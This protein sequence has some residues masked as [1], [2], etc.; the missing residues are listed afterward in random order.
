MAENKRDYYEVLGVSKGASEEEIKKAYKKLARKYHP[1]MNPGDKEAEEKFKEINEAN[2]VLSDPKKR[3]LYDQYGFAGVDPN[4]AAQNGGG[5]GGFG[6][7][8]GFGGDGVDLGDIFGDIFGGGFGGFGGSSRS[9]NPNAPRKGQDIRVRI[10]LTFD[11][12]VHGCKKNITITRQQE[13]TECHGSGCAA[14]SSPETCPDCGG[15]GFVIRQQRTP[16]GVMQTQQP[17][18]RCGGKGKLIKN[19]CRSCHGGGT[20]AVKKTLEANVPAGIDDDQGFRLSGMGNAGT[21]GGPAGDVI[22]AVTVQPSEV[23]QRDENNIYVVFPITY[24]QAVLGDTITVPS[25]DGKVEVNVPEGTQSGTT[26]RLR[27]K[28]IQY[29]NGRGRGDMYVKCEVEIPKKLSRTQREALKKFEGTL[30]EDNYEK[31]KGFFKKL[32]DMFNN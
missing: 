12:A 7:F 1:D 16:F 3:Q 10:T 30:K 9:A 25:I 5:P 26:F 28:G 23:F 19:P 6:G 27:G 21:N 18:S 22:V 17:C 14:G 29:V 20:I 13:C 4:Y 15:R 11:E 8:S 31:R 32:K 2:E 24:S